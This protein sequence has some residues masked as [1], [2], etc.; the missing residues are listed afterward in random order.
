MASEA[1]SHARAGRRN[2]PAK[3]N[4]PEQTRTHDFYSRLLSHF[5]TYRRGHRETPPGGRRGEGFTVRQT[6]VC[7]A[8][9]HSLVYIHIFMLTSPGK[10]ETPKPP[11]FRAIGDTVLI[12]Q[13]RSSSDRAF[14]RP[15]VCGTACEAGGDSG[16][17]RRRTPESGYETLDCLGTRGARQGRAG[18]S[19]Q[20]TRRDCTDGVGKTTKST[21]RSGRFQI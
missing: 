12:S 9:P 6:H 16:I 17:R 18:F 21:K 7:V 14:R 11:G 15:R 2:G 1:R 13:R 19:H 4:Q 8:A 5:L 20:Q 3:L 10:A